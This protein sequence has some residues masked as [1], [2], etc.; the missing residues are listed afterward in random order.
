M[1]YAKAQK[2]KPAVSSFRLP[3]N[4]LRVVDSYCEESDLTRSQLFRKLLKN[5]EPL[6]DHASDQHP[7]LPTDQPVSGWSVN[8]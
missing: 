4:L 8:R 5:F 1:N 6:K 3:E 2:P 7:V